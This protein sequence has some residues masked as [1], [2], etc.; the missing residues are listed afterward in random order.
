MPIVKVQ[1][2]LEADSGLPEDVTVNSFYFETAALPEYENPVPIFAVEAFYTQIATFLS[3]WLSGHIVH[4]LYEMSDPEPRI[5][6]VQ[7]GQDIVPGSGALVNEVAVC[8]SFRGAY[9]SGLPNARR[10]G[11]VYIG[12]LAEGAQGPS[13][14][15]R[16]SDNIRTALLAGAQALKGALDGTPWDWVV[17]SPTT[18]GISPGA[19]GA[20]FPVVQAWVDDAFDTQR[21]RGVAPT[22]RTTAVISQ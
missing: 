21:R 14:P 16:P 22:M 9:E 6:R 10:R 20:G 15:K 5:P 7:T 11:R 19:A 2:T 3:V 12:P 4:K 8:L 18:A 13:T 17:Y 1:S